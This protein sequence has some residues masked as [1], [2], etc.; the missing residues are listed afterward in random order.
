MTGIWVFEIAL[1]ALII[2]MI[3]WFRSRH[4]A[5]FAEY[6][7]LKKKCEQAIKGRQEAESAAQA[8]IFAEES[9]KSNLQSINETVRLGNEQ[10]KNNEQTLLEQERIIR[11]KIE[12]ERS[13][14]LKDMEKQQQAILLE[15]QKEFAEQFAANTKTKLAAAQQLTEQVTQLKSTVAS[16]VE[17]AKHKMEEESAS[18]FYRLQLPQESVDD[19]EALRSIESMLHNSE[20]INKVI[21]KMYYEKPYTDL[22]GRLGLNNT[23]CGIYKITNTTNQMTYVGQAV[24]IADRWK[25]HIK[26]GVG[27]DTPTQNKLY[28]AM[29]QFGPENFTFEVVEKCSREKLNEREDYWQ[30]FYKAK[31]FGYS[32]K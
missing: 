1:L 30:D 26:R 15:A 18:D 13:M 3:C 5:K 16:A 32:I 9:A 6:Q 7:E 2:C 22:I 21:W 4:Y 14:W 10:L 20:A 29:K 31:E 23:V 25:Q 27:A 28:P 24:N 17:I 12:Y 11:E 8:A 19:I